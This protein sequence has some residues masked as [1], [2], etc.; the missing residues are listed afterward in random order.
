MAETNSENCPCSGKT[1]A[2]LVHPAIL[3]A[4][5]KGEAHGYEIAQRLAE[6]SSFA[7]PDAAGI[8]R[9]LN[10]MERDGYVESRW[11]APQAGPPRKVFQLTASG[12]ACLVQWRRTLRAYRGDLDRLLA[13]I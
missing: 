3:G 1:L 13:V 5:S 8:Y 11:D 4:L 2:R 7:A 12:R 10:L 6:L 9:A